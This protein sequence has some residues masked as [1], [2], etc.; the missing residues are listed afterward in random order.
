[1]FDI[2]WKKYKN[3]KPKNLMRT[4][5]LKNNNGSKVG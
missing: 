3:K 1:M 2:L 4:V 5:N